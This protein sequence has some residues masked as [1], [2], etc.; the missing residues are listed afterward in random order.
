MTGLDPARLVGDLPQAI[1]RVAGLSARER[2][3]EAELCADLIGSAADTL[4][5]VKKV[6]K[7]EPQP[8]DVYAAITFGLAILAHRQGGVA[9]GGMHWC[10]AEHPDCP[11]L[12]AWQVGGSASRSARGA[13]FTPRTLA[14]EVTFGALED[15]VFRPGPNTTADQSAWRIKPSVE[16]LRLKVGDIAVGSGVFLLAGCRYLADR[17]VE[18]WF[19]EADH[20]SQD[21][22]PLNPMTVA[23]RRLVMR[24]LYGVDIDPT[25]VELCRLALALLAPLTPLDLSDRIVCGDSLLGITSLDQLDRMSL[26]PKAPLRPV[27]DPKL[28]RLL[29]QVEAHLREESAG[30]A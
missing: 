26:D 15:L 1:G 16:I 25:S 13:F 17:L 10:A 22:P 11:G 18:A 7:S 29:S 19:A 9:F 21:L 28:V 30:A 12:G 23:A 2:L 27:M 24:C 3:A 4:W 6:H 14:E 5:A 20:P 8:E